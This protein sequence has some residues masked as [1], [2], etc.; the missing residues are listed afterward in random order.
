MMRISR[1]RRYPIKGLA[2]KD[3]N[4]LELSAGAGV[5]L[6]RR[7]ALSFGDRLIGLSEDPRLARVF[8][9]GRFAKAALRSIGTEYRPRKAAPAETGIWRMSN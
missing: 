4:S 3:M 9:R 6:D 5:P 8:G 7:F 1:I 2:G